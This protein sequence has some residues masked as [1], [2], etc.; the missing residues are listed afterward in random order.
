MSL[1]ERKPGRNLQPP[2]VSCA[3]KESPTAI[4]SWNSAPQKRL[5]IFQVS[6]TDACEGMDNGKLNNLSMFF[7]DPCSQPSSTQSPPRSPTSFALLLQ[8]PSAGDTA[9]S[10][11]V[12]N[13][14]PGFVSSP[15]FEVTATAQMTGSSSSGFQITGSF[16]VTPPAGV[17]S[18]FDL[19]IRMPRQFRANNTGVSGGFYFGSC[20]SSSGNFD[21]NLIQESDGAYTSGEILGL[22]AGVE[23][24]VRFS[25]LLVQ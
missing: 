18:P 22:S 9:L 20:A 7:S 4:M 11:R 24:T 21:S 2:C 16:R 19:F 8:S 23:C 15:A 6:P 14:I 13:S 17:N 25:V 3:R 5:H 12:T 10:L 1:D